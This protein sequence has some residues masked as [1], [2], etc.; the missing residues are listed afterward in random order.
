M[1]WSGPWTGPLEWSTGLLDWSTGSGAC[2]ED[3]S[4]RNKCNCII[5]TMS[6]DYYGICHIARRILIGTP[7]IRTAE[8]ASPRKCSISTRLL[9]SREGGV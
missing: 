2:A 4:Y 9:S 5:T 8:S 7:E 3:K 1:D 6:N